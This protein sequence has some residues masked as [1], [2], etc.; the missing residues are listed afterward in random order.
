MLRR[1]GPFLRHFLLERNCSAGYSSYCSEVPNAQHGCSW[2]AARSLAQAAA[3]GAR[4]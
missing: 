1:A 4:E 3:C 2:P